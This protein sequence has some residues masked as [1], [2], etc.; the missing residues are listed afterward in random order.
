MSHERSSGEGFPR[1][2]IKPYEADIVRTSHSSGLTYTSVGQIAS[3]IGTLSMETTQFSLKG[4]TD[5]TA[6]QDNDDVYLMDEQGDVH[7]KNIRNINRVE[8][9]AVYVSVN[10]V[11]GDNDEME[12]KGDLDLQVWVENGKG[13]RTALGYAGSFR[14]AL[15]E[16]YTDESGSKML[17]VPVTEEFLKKITIAFESP[18]HFYELR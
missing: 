5:L 12:R 11:T 14:Q 1:R 15:D 2:G 9:G 13:V 6:W 3:G 10:G 8:N 17:F 18:S 4:L 16:F 7:S